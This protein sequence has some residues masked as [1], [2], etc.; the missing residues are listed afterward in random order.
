MIT[1][2]RRFPADALEYFDRDEIERG[3]AYNRP[4]ERLKLVRTALTAAIAIAFIAGDVG[5]RVIDSLGWRGWALNVLLVAAV[6]TLVDVVASWW[7]DAHREL[8]WDRQW[9]LSTQTTAGFLA[10]QAKN[11]IVGIVLNAL[12]LVPLWAVI[13]ATDL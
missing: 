2:W 12:L 5:P 11:L 4:I 7:F 3:R 13:R 9:E 1:H 6:F 8:V 10:D